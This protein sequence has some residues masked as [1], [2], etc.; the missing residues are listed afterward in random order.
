VGKIVFTTEAPTDSLPTST[1]SPDGL[2]HFTFVTASRSVARSGSIN[3]DR[4][5][6]QLNLKTIDSMDWVTNKR[7]ELLFSDVVAQETSYGCWGSITAPASQLSQAISFI[8]VTAYLPVSV[9]NCCRRYK[10]FRTLPLVSLQELESARLLSCVSFIGYRFDGG[11]RSRQ[12]FWHTSVNMVRLSNTCSR[13]VSRRQ[14][15]LAV[16]TCV[17]HRRDSWST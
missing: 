1:A 2:H 5:A 13:T 14:C 8:T 3:K 6:T 12:R 11:S 15:A 7:T 10:L 4:I 16:V 9:I 17:V